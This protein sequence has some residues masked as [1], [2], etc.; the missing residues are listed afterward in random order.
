MIIGGIKM[1]KELFAITESNRFIADEFAR[2]TGKTKV[3]FFNEC[4]HCHFQPKIEKL[5]VEYEYLINRYNG[6]LKQR[7]VKFNEDGTQDIGNPSQFE[8]KQA[9]GRAATY[10]L[11]HHVE[12]CAPFKWIIY[13]HFI[14]DDRDQTW[15]E[16]RNEMVLKDVDNA[17]TML[18]EKIKYFGKNNPVAMLM[19]VFDNWELFW[20]DDRS[21]N[22]LADIIYC[23]D[24]YHPIGL[25][26][27]LSLLYE[28][29]RI[30]LDDILKEEK[31]RVLEGK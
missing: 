30:I 11:K 3:S 16:N 14:N 10:C 4:I 12:D 1:K 19:E 31:H 23:W 18:N 28:V 6:E 29:D 25:Y 27:A 5:M 20:D 21:Y 9:I 13:E 7:I 26:D 8:L 22:L 24:T 15:K 17:Y 2:V